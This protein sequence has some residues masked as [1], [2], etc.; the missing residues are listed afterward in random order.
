MKLKVPVVLAILICS[1]ALA[2][3]PASQVKKA[4]VFGTVKDK[5]TLAALAGVRV[6]LLPTGFS[7]ETDSRGNFRFADIIP[8][9]YQLLF[10]KDGFLPFVA[11]IN[12]PAEK[13]EVRAE[14]V[15]EAIHKEITVTADKFSRPETVASSRQSLSGTQVRSLPGIFEDV[16]RAL[17]VIPG[18]AS[19]GD[20][21]NGLIVRGGSPIE[22]LY[23]LDWIQ[24]PGLSHFGSQNSSGGAIGLLNTDLVKDIEFYSGGFPA[25]FG[26]KLSS[27]TR[28]GLREGNRSRFSGNVN[29]S[30]FGVSGVAEGPLFSS[31]GSWIFSLR[32]DYFST[33]PP[34]MTLGLTVIPD[35]TDA[36]VKIVYNLSSRLQLSVLGLGANDSLNIEESDEPPERRMKIN[37][38]DHQY[39]AGATLKSLLGKGG[40]A[41]FTLSRTDSRYSYSFSSS[42]L[43]R[44]TIRSEDKETSVRL[45]LEYFLLPKLQFMSGFSIKKIQANHHVYYRGGYIVID[46]MGFRFTRKNMDASLYGDKLA[47]YLQASYPLTEKLKATA[48]IRGDYFGLIDDFTLSPRL[49]LSYAFLAESAIHLSY[50]VYF[51]S[52]ETFWIGS[53]PD[54]IHLPS[55]RSAHV[56]FGVEHKI[57][58]NLKIRVEI[59][60]KTYDHYPVD[61]ANPYLTLANLGGSMV[62]TFFGS[63]LVGVGSGYARGFEISVEKSL[64]GKFS[65][66]IDYSYA[67]V[68][69]KALD[70]I[71]RNGDFDFRHILNAVASYR[72]SATFE[73][74]VKWRYTGGQP[75]TPF[76]LTL[77]ELKNDSYFDMTA[78][79]TLRYP[80]Y[81][82]LDLRLEKKFVFKKWSL[83]AYLDVQN[84]YNRKNVYFTFWE[85]KTQKTVY[86]LPL[87]PLV[88]LQAGF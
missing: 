61:S 18:V 39:V 76:D 55:L 50:G 25:Y 35:F 60:D 72:L 65:W 31:R 74:S 22:N 67:V 54:N 70:G 2:A 53:H 83:E 14:A 81:H 64:A 33:I 59:Y 58:R 3:D 42:G 10:E 46:R 7:A 48:G 4:A 57:A 19:S 85:D 6:S 12:V 15:L 40:V 88:G 78:I 52:P 34:D 73:V 66:F 37:I 11:N 24:V 45:D 30:L 86:Y 84:L 28:I 41:Y 29:L 75:Y 68:K 77:S 16:S 8:G 17:Q 20:F 27:V 1:A 43:E 82:R 87:I 71:L 32:K 44:Y 56:V 23:M 79:N 21:T 26:D 63:K 80:P 69:Y 13:N 62:P 9:S 47:F 5:V 49:G 36:Q 51:Q 38:G